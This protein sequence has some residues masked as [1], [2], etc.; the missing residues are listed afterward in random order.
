MEINKEKF[1]KQIKEM[2]R[3]IEFRNEE[4]MML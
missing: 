3:T 1:N 4:I 2:D